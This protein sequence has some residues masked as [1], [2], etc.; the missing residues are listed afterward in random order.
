M[1]TNSSVTNK[2]W[3]SYATKKLKVANIDSANLDALIILCFSL[4]QTKIEIL[5][6]P[7]NKLSKTQTALANKL[8]ERRAL[9]YPIVYITQSIEFY[10]YTFYVD[11]RV[12]SPRPE[13][14][15]FINLLKSENISNLKFL[16]DVGC[17]S[18]VLGITTKIIFPYLNVELLD[19]SKNALKVTEIN[20]SNFGIAAKVRL[21]NLLSSSN[22]KY[23]IILANLPYVPDSMQVSSAVLFEPKMA[24]F[25]GRDGLRFYRNM[26][27]Q[28]KQTGHRPKYI[29][30]ECLDNQATTINGLLSELGYRLIRSEG[31]VHM[32]LYDLKKTGY[33]L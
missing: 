26:L 6:G 24:I 22:N 2:L 17:G 32:F 11:S 23:D 19:K 30:I 28:L 8:L 14:E 25:A 31:I 21:S 18:G 33:R 16:T 27:K 13:S 3:L 12:L 9:N 5:S 1:N 4:K 10:N 20:L 29:L 7:D 15:S